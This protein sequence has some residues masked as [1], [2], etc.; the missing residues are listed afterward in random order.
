MYTILVV[1]IPKQNWSELRD[2]F[3]QHVNNRRNESSE[4]LI[5]DYYSIKNIVKLRKEL[6]T[7]LSKFEEMKAKS[8][9]AGSSE[10]NNKNFADATELA[11][12]LM[13]NEE[14]LQSEKWK[15][16]KI[17]TVIEGLKEQISET[18]V[19]TLKVE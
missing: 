8:R 12:F 15:L 14:I 19:S 9:A 18:E 17:S 13:S 3:R 5:L 6:L 10:S 16:E 2:S 1:E 7:L 11:K 4:N